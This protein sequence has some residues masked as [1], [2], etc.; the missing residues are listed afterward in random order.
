[1]ARKKSFDDV[2]DPLRKIRPP[3]ERT[4]DAPDCAAAAEHRAPKAPNDL[5]S[6]HWF[7]LE[8]VQQYNRAWNYYAG[9]SP[10]EI[11]RQIQFDTIWQR[12]T[13]PL[14]SGRS[15]SWSERPEDF[16]DPFDIFAEE[17][18]EAAASRRAQSKRAA[19]EVTPV[20]E[21]ALDTLGLAAPVSGKEIKAR[22]KELVKALHPDANG[23]DKQAEERLRIVIEAYTTLTRSPKERDPVQT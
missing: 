21:R 5:N 15:F 6:F 16:G 12:P 8:H 14:G 19:V 10:E 17:R 7:C 2:F 13:W 1:M 3:D 4:C 20:F 22:F 18:E 11:E 23:G 9:M